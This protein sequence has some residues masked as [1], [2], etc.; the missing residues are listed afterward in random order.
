M[1]AELAKAKVS[2]PKVNA[3]FAKVSVESAKVIFVINVPTIVPVGKDASD[4]TNN[5]S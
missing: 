2:A 3:E 1:R 5:P 4:L